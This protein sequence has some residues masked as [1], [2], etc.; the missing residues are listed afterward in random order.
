MILYGALFSAF[1]LLSPFL[2]A[3]LAGLGLD[4]EQVGFVLGLATRC[5]SYVVPL[6][7]VSRMLFR[8]FEQ[9]LLFARFWLQAPRSFTS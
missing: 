9:N 2:P 6:L 3:F 5:G 8:P 1:G 7:G 4:S